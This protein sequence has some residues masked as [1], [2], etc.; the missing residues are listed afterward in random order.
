MKMRFCCRK[1]KM[2]VVQGEVTITVMGNLEIITINRANKG[3][4]VELKYC[5]F[6]GE[7]IE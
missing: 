5:P 1:M 3:I 7:E 2:A 6:C 4:A